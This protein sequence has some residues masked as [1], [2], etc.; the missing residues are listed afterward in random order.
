MHFS[1][2]SLAAFSILFSAAYATPVAEPAAA[3]Q[4]TES[5]KIIHINYVCNKET[6]ADACSS[7]KEYLLRKENNGCD[8]FGKPPF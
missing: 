6:S 2:A 4:P 7:A 3:P 5:R 8:V 1:A